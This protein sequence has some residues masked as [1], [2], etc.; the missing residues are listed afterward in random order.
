MKILKILGLGILV[1]GCADREADLE[2]ARYLLAR[3]DIG[4]A[5]EALTYVSGIVTT[6]A[7]DPDYFE[8]VRLY[9]GAKIALAGFTPTQ[10]VS[11][12]IHPEST[13]TAKRLRPA[14]SNL[15]SD[16]ATLLGEALTAA[17]AAAGT[18]AFSSQALRVQQDIQFNRGLV[19]FLRAIYVGLKDSTYLDNSSAADFDA[20]IGGPCRLALAGAATTQMSSDIS[21]AQDYF[22]QGGSE[23]ASESAGFTSSNPLVKLVTDMD[24][25]IKTLGGGSITTAAICLWLDTQ[26]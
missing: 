17:N 20:G 6:G 8:A 3:G 14:L 10:I 12:V 9:V 2:R 23:A 1:A 5:T 18:T 22:E 15:Q 11:A 4:S 13:N 24:D 19:Y 16:G 7:T 21:N 25:G 26:F